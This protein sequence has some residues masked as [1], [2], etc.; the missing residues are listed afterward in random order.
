VFAGLPFQNHRPGA[1]DRH[2]GAVGESD[3]TIDLV[4]EVLECG[5]A[6]RHMVGGTSV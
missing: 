4:V 1:F 2:R 5:A 3:D 6:P